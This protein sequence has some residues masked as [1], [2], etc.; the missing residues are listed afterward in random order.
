VHRD[1]EQTRGLEADGW[2]VLR[3]WEHQVFEELPQVVAQIEEAME[4]GPWVPPASSRV[5][6]VD[7]VTADGQLERRFLESLRSPIATQEVVRERTTR[8][9]TRGDASHTLPR[10]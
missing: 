1:Q 5:V 6:K 2:R 4:V 3:F 9:W 7:V 8:K 10:R